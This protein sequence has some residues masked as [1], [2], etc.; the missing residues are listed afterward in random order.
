MNTQS[1]AGNDIGAAARYAVRIPWIEAMPREPSSHPE[2]A[3]AAGEVTA[4]L[5]A[6]HRQGG[7]GREDIDHLFGLIYAE[8]RRI[9]QRTLGPGQAATLNPTALVHEAYAKL[10]GGDALEIEGRRHFLALCARVMRQ[11]V[12]DHARGRCADKRGGGAAP[13]ALDDNDPLDLSR[14]ESLLAL[15]RALERL[16]ERDPRLVH[17]LHYRVFAGLELAEIAPLLEVTV[18][19]L[20]RDWQRAR[21]WLVDEMLDGEA[22]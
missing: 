10:I 20:Q 1:R 7:L 6:A 11:I 9:A 16:E 18:R 4:I 5:S 21:I 12:I 15:D 14:P 22:P 17:L 3:A 2:P 13:L 19:Q 8:L